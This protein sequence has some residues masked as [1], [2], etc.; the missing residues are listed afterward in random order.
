MR[1]SL[2]NTLQHI[3]PD[4]SSHVVNIFHRDVL[5]AGVDGGL[6]GVLPAVDDLHILLGLSVQLSS[7]VGES[8]LDS[9]YEDD[10]LYLVQ[11]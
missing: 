5:H 2:S 4:T 11:Q 7:L 9:L 3:I 6:P 1:Y 10:I 8:K